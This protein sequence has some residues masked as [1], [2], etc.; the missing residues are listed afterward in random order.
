MR[1]EDNKLLCANTFENRVPNLLCTDISSYSVATI[2]GGQERKLCA[3]SE[4]LAPIPDRFD[5]RRSEK[6]FVSLADQGFLGSSGVL[7][8][9]MKNS[10]QRLRKRFA[11]YPR[12]D[13]RVGGVKINFVIKDPDLGFLSRLTAGREDEIAQILVLSAFELNIQ[14]L[15]V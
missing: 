1:A 5:F 9:G 8:F 10:P 7:Q 15:R 14:G 6:L 2:I 11:L 3:S 12:S 4:T 13:A